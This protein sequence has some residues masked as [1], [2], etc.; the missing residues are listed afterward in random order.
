[1]DRKSFTSAFYYILFDRIWSKTFFP[2]A[3]YGNIYHISKN[4]LHYISIMVIIPY[5]IKKFI[6][7]YHLGSKRSLNMGR[8]GYSKNPCS[9]TTKYLIEKRPALFE[10]CQGAVSNYSII[11]PDAPVRRQNLSIRPII[12]A[13]DRRNSKPGCWSIDPLLHRPIL[14]QS[15]K[16]ER[17]P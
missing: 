11:L 9:S 7:L 2:Y 17:S 3:N 1:M 8:A 5:I 10:N 12:S 4:F 16:Q 15:Q 6:D 14:L 13:D